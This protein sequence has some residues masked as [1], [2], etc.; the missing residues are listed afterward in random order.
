MKKIKL[1]LTTILLL[2][3][4]VGCGGNQYQA[5]NTDTVTPAPEDSIDYE[6]TE[7]SKYLKSVVC[8][9]EPSYFNM[10]ID[11]FIEKYN[12]IVDR[13]TV[14][15][16][17]KPLMQLNDSP[18]TPGSADGVDIYN[19]TNPVVLQNRSAVNLMVSTLEGTS[20]VHSVNIAVPSGAGPNTD[21]TDQFILAILALTEDSDD[22][23][24]ETI[25][26]MVS[27]LKENGCAYYKGLFMG[28]YDQDTVRV[29]RIGAMTEETYNQ[30]S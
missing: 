8:E 28:Y 19:V 13:S 15:E 27:E 16:N 25:D 29:Y 6:V 2:T 21:I 26:N 9:S 3:S 18:G 5:N 1:I 24:S 12:S 20:T 4:L 10:T 11:E 22:I 30:I 23:P 7:E 17:V 14:D